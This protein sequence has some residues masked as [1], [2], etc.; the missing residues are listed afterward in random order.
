[1]Y[2]LNYI[3]VNIVLVEFSN[4]NFNF[5]V[6]IMTWLVEIQSPQKRLIY[7]LTLSLL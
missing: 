5:E 3:N 2:K 4:A 1:M 7:K 6:T